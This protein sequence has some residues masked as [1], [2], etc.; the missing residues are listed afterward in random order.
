M[1]QDKQK[2]VDSRVQ[3]LEKHSSGTKRVVGSL[4]PIL[5]QFLIILLI[6]AVAYGA[7]KY[8]IKTGSSDNSQLTN[9]ASELNNNLPSEKSSSEEN[10]IWTCSMHPQIKMNKPGQCPI[11]GMDLVP[12]SALE[13]KGESERRFK[14]TN[15]SVA[16]AEI[17]TA[18]VQR[19]WVDNTV[20]MVGNI[21]HDETRLVYITAY[22]SGRLDRLF[23]DY[24][25]IAVKQS[26]HMASIYSPDLVTAQEEL[27]QA[28]NTFENLKD[29]ATISLRESTQ[30]TLESARERLRL[31]GLTSQQIQGIEV[32]GT[33]EDHLTLFAPVGGIVIK[34]H[35]N[36]GD[37]VKTGDRIYTISDL[38]HLWVRL[39][40]YESDLTWLRYGQDVVFTT[41]AY[42]SEEFHGRISFI[43]PVLNS[44]SRTVGVRVNVYN[45]DRRLK[46]GMFVRAQVQSRLASGGKVIDSSLAG[47]WICPMHPEVLK[48]SAGNCDICNMELVPVEEIGYV[49]TVPDISP[50]VIPKTAPLITG[51]RAVVYV[52][53]PD[54]ERPTFEGREIVLG[55]RAGDYYLVKSGLEEGERIVVR[56]SFK[57]DSAL[58]IIAKPSMMNPDGGIATTG[59]EGHQMVGSTMQNNTKINDKKIKKG[60]VDPGN[61]SNPAFV[62]PQLPLEVSAEFRS[63]LDPIYN[64]YFRIGTALANDDLVEAQAGF[65]T[66]GQVTAEYRLASNESGAAQA[67]LVYIEDIQSSASEGAS[68]D[69][70]SAARITFEKLSK[71][72][73]N[74]HRLAG[75][76]YDKTFYLVHCPMAFDMKGADWMQTTDQI[77][78]PYFGAKM[79][80]CGEV[81]ETYSPELKN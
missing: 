7:Y 80:K 42:P 78:N 68:S 35:V 55:P 79:L 11:C 49:A 28:K 65:K 14:M 12:Q 2:N 18:P 22:V 75:H 25:G 43:D 5:I 16:L 9:L 72:V 61:S 59:H 62:P 54:E 27:I 24:T 60:T 45:Q 47:K 8:G 70:L 69:D 76:A 10:I 48:D 33:V 67:C 81:K 37:Y 30:Q 51:K 38:D 3:N 53:I 40:A 74:M 77:A 34:K 21:D 36:E 29:G 44:M 46:P 20:R 39:E 52:E 66:L 57:I 58:Q 17:K 64:A 50:V 1:T 4:V 6:L 19:M 32:S 63:R 15:E 26:D 41:E 23:V 13:E 31:W 56:G 73:I 71:P